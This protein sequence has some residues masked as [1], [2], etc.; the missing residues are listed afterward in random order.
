MRTVLI[1][2]LMA[3]KSYSQS[4]FIIVSPSAPP[5]SNVVDDINK[6][7]YYVFQLKDS[8][9]CE[10][11]KNMLGL[12][13]A[14]QNFEDTEDLKTKK[15]LVQ[16][17]TAIPSKR[18]WINIKLSRGFMLW[19]AQKNKDNE[20]RRKMVLLEIAEKNKQLERLNLDVFLY[21]KTV[22]QEVANKVVK[23]SVFK[24]N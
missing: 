22:E 6:L 24:K 23:M 8:V 11:L 10:L 9:Q 20:D 15:L 7:N 21:P 17:T 3:F 12:Y 19:Y 5:V 2:F 13:L 16:I 18:S 4:R 14:T 1:V